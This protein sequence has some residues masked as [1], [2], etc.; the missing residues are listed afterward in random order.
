MT[1]DLANFIGVCLLTKNNLIN[2]SL[3][4]RVWLGNPWDIDTSELGL[5]GLDK[6]HK[7]PHSKDMLLHKDRDISDITESLVEVMGLE[8]SSDG[9]ELF[10]DVIGAP[11]DLG[12]GSKIGLGG[13][14]GHRVGDIGKFRGAH[15]VRM[16]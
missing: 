5:E 6:T 4:F 2:E 7:V 9:E 3:D 16:L 8:D 14:L 11:L 13:N 12:G 10:L 1:L 15:E